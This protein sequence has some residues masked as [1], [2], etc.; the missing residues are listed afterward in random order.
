MIIQ[1]LVTYFCF[2]YKTKINTYQV[3]QLIR[4]NRDS[5]F[6]GLTTFKTKATNSRKF[7]SV[8]IHYDSRIL[9]YTQ[10]MV[11]PLILYSNSKNSFI[12]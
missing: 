9:S 2:I 7:S 10:L 6:L 4:P 3:I 12:Q 11:I 5:I 8:L 1:F